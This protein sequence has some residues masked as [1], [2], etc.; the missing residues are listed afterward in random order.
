MSELENAIIMIVDVFDKYACTEGNKRTL[1]KGEMK[2]LMEKEL[3][4]LYSNAKKKDA[5]AKLLKDL[6]DDSSV[7]VN[8]E[9]FI[10]L[11]ARLLVITEPER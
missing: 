5:S 6:D 1:T 11:L 3:P 10:D 7:Y 9:K 4:R 2:T 8:F